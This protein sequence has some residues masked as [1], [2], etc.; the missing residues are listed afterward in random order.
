MDDN[1]LDKRLEDVGWLQSER[2]KLIELSNKLVEGKRNFLIPTTAVSATIIAGLL[3][4]MTTAA[5]YDWRFVVGASLFA[6]TASAT[7]MYLTILLSLESHK[8]DHEV[9]LL[10]GTLNG[11]KEK[12]RQGATDP[13]IYSQILTWVPD[14]R[15]KFEKIYRL[16]EY[17][18]KE[19]FFV[20]SNL[21]FV[22]AFLWLFFAFLCLI[23]W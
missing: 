22:T 12:V 7:H 16:L 18:S 5:N 20:L 8:L 15:K 23:V 19:Q 2:D 17:L 1:F 9:N 21:L 13:A 4:F 10:N 3:I 6:L 11:Y 14:E